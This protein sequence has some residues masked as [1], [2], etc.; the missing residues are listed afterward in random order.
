MKLDRP[1]LR[2]HKTL[3]LI[4]QEEVAE[5]KKRLR[6]SIL[7]TPSDI[8]SGI[9]IVSEDD[10]MESYTENVKTNRCTVVR[11]GNKVE[12]LQEGDYCI[13]EPNTGAELTY[14]DKTYRLIKEDDI[15]IIIEK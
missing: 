8:V 6:E 1:N 4:E 3:V 9:V 10:M 15:K 14:R 11:V 5:T 12:E 7:D 2:P 13:F